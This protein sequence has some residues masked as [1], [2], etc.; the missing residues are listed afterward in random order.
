MNHLSRRWTTQGALMTHQGCGECSCYVVGL[1][2]SLLPSIRSKAFLVVSLICIPTVY[3]P[4]KNY[5]GPLFVLYSCILTK[6]NE[7]I[8]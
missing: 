3:K 4:C 8:K 2:L 1:N 6:V 7:K 5:L